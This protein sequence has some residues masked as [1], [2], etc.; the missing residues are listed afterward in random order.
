MDVSTEN[1]YYPAQT[2]GNQWW[3]DKLKSTQVST[4]VDETSGVP[5]GY[6]PNQLDATQRNLFFWNNNT[7]R[8]L[9]CQEQTAEI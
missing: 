9:D 1:E 3:V 2:S 6:N 5:L 4:D 8:E 7:R